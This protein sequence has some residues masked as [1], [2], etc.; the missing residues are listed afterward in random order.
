MHKFFEGDASRPK[1]Q[2]LKENRME[3]SGAEK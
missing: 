3:S 1:L 2:L